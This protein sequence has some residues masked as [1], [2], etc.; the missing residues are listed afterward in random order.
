MA[1]SSTDRQDLLPAFPPGTAVRIFLVEDSAAI[2][3]LI[4]EDLATIPGIC[5]IGFAETEDEA[6][7]QL[8]A[9]KC[10][11]LILDIQLRQGNGI[12]LLRTLSADPVHRDSL[13]VVLSNHA[14][15]TYRRICE[16]YGVRFFFDKTSEFPQLHLLLGR[17]GVRQDKA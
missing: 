3:D 15:P 16:Q 2:R 10:D 7:Q 1:D 13:K 5:L 8:G 6:L 17:L 11:V 4:I 14:S 12:N 9:T